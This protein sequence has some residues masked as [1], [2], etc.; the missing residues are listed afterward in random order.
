MTEARK[1][2]LSSITY[3]ATGLRLKL[4]RKVDDYL[5][6]HNISRKDFATQLGV[7]K[8]YISQVLN[9]EADVRISKLV[10]FS[11]AIGMVPVINWV[12]LD[13][14]LAANGRPERLLM[15]SKS[16]EYSKPTTARV[17]LQN[18]ERAHGV[19]YSAADNYQDIVLASGK[20][21][22]TDTSIKI[23]D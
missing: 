15:T 19:A 16:V 9:G 12:P 11:L 22:V 23:N 17:M 5:T 14:Y 18:M 2:L 3:H 4:F 21:C 6:T 10:Q 1:D 7:T 20:T 8:G 13:R